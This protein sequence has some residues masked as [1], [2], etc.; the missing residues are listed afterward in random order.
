MFL[1]FLSVGKSN[2]HLYIESDTHLTPQGAQ[3]DAKGFADQLRALKLAPEAAKEFQTQS[4][5]IIR[6]G[7]ILD[8]MQIPG[9]REAFRP[10]NVECD[11]VLDPASGPLVP[12]ASDRPGTYRYPGQGTSVLVL[13]DSFCR[14]YQFPE[15]QS[16]GDTPTTTAP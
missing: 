13:G 12:T 8:M 9:L 2:A 6:W 14:I 16:L 7:D 15:P 10:E 4:V 5:S 1:E 3:L 11:Q